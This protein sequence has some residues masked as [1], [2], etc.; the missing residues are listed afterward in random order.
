MEQKGTHEKHLSVLD[1]EKQERSKEV[2]ALEE[3]CI[4]L[5]ETNRSYEETEERLHGQLCDKDHQIREAQRR[6]DE[7]E[8]EAETM[9][10]KAKAAQKKLSVLTSNMKQVEQ[11]VL[12]YERSPDE[13]L[14][15]A[16]TLESA[17]TYRKRAIPVIA[18][19]LEIIQPLYSKYYDLKIK[20]DRLKSR[21]SDLNGQIYRMQDRLVHAKEENQT[22]RN[23]IQDFNM[24]KSIL[25]ENVIAD[26]IRR[27]K[28]YEQIQMAQRTYNRKH[29][30]DTECLN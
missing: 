17:K 5:E 13:W 29:S 28:E 23:Q 1:Y 24:A 16:N 27:A 25:G 12:K 7:A 9:E 8:A 18:K 4:A 22:L 11:A 3:R 30:R 15:E 19:A 14:P 26:A 6:R 21:E 2:A 10:E 20:C